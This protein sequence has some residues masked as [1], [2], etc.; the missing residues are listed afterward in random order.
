MDINVTLYWRLRS[1]DWTIT[2]AADADVAADEDKDARWDMAVGR[3]LYTCN[4]RL[5]RETV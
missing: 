2:K 5:R 1:D 4:G 3:F